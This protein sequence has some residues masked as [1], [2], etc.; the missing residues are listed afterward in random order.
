MLQNT[1]G[2]LDFVWS[3]NTVQSHN[4]FRYMRK[5]SRSKSWKKAHIFYQKGH[6]SR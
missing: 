2:D 5:A 6:Y 3:E 1:G 4:T